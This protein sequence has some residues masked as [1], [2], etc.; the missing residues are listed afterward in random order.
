MS[1]Q[2][3]VVVVAGIVLALI[4]ACC[5]GIA[6]TDSD[7]DSGPT[8]KYSQTECEALRASALSDSNPNREDDFVQWDVHC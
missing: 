4:V 2:Q 3:L 6:R 7:T 8:G 1:P 5:C